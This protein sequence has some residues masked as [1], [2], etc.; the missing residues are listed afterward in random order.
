VI[1]LHFLNKCLKEIESGQKKTPEQSQIPRTGASIIRKK[2]QKSMKSHCSQ[3][4]LRKH[5]NVNF[6][7]SIIVFPS[8]NLWHSYV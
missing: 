3:S 2:P 4:R 5:E 6:W 7:S 1:S 8:Q